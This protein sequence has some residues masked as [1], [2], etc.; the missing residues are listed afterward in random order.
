MNEP[1]DIS[2]Q[3]AA[4]RVHVRAVRADIDLD[5]C[6]EDSA[7][8][9]EN[10]LAMVELT[11]ASIVL[12]YRAMPEEIDPAPTLRALRASGVAIAYPRIEAPGIVRLH[13]AT[14]DTVWLPGPFGLAEPPADTPCVDPALIDAV[15]VPGVAFDPAGG[16][17][18]IGGGYYDRLIPQFRTDCLLIGIAFDEQVLDEVPVEAHD[19]RVHAVATPTRVLRAKP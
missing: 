5:K 8:L 18:G 17:L 6:L 14:A 7:K 1:L 2:A 15:L 16:R 4:I 12:A 3:K 10:L 19:A 11:A 9:A 13:L